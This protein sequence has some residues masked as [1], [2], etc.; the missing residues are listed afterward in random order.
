ME[1]LLHGTASSLQRQD[2]GSHLDRCARCREA[3]DQARWVSQRLGRGGLPDAGR[4]DWTA[5]EAA[6]EPRKFW[7]PDELAALLGLSRARL[8]W[9][10]AIAAAALIALFAM[11]RLG[12]PL[13]DQVKASAHLVDTQRQVAL[14]ETGAAVVSVDGEL[15]HGTTAIAVGQRV[16]VEGG[17]AKMRSVT[18]VELQLTSGV[19]GA[20]VQLSARALEWRLK[21][22]VIL[23]HVAPQRSG[24]AVWIHTD[25]MR[26]RVVGTVFSVEKTDDLTRVQ[27]MEG[28]VS[29]QPIG[30]AVPIVVGALQ[31]IA[32]SMTGKV[33]IGQ[34][35][36]PMIDLPPPPAST[37]R[38]KK[39]RI[40]RSL[41]P[42]QRKVRVRQILLRLRALDGR[43]AGL[44]KLHGENGA[45]LR[46]VAT[47]LARLSRRDRS[48]HTRSFGQL[49]DDQQRIA[50]QIQQTLG[51]I[52]ELTRE[53]LRLRGQGK[54]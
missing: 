13:A 45:L 42:R 39:K 41:S 31:Q 52:N 26:L 15:R 28:R 6:L 33:T 25:E 19:D 7:H 43:L 47:G 32:I 27:V 30:R 29:V 16:E 11:A 23:L 36:L 35:L 9:F 49:T 10:S 48:R 54:E 4:P 34:L 24:A 3:L 44:R 37:R 53:L 12:G 51:E 8:R 2:L 18:G 50:R 1:G 40:R 20:L 38:L 5:L 17:V 22:G 46:A 14:L 21:R